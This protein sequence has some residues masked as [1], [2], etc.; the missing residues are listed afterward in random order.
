MLGTVR[1]SIGNCSAEGINGL[2]RKGERKRFDEF[3]IM[4]DIDLPVMRGE[5]RHDIMP[6]QF[7]AVEVFSAV[8]LDTTVGVDFS[9]PRDQALH[10]G[11][12]QMIPAV[13]VRIESKAGGQTT[14]IRPK[15][16]S[17]DSGKTGSMVGH[18]EAPVGLPDVIIIVESITAKLASIGSAFTAMW[19]FP[20]CQHL[21]GGVGET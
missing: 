12:G 7:P 2:P 17:E 21:L 11:R 16:I 10:N 14:G 8:E 20:F 3:P 1:T 4:L 19:M 15:S 5:R 6:F 9:N 13:E 18:G